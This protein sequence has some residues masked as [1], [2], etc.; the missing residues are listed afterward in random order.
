MHFHKNTSTNAYDVQPDGFLSA[1]VT[2]VTDVTL[3]VTAPNSR[4]GARC[5]NIT[6]ALSISVVSVLRVCFRSSR[7][8]EL[9]VTDSAASRM[10]R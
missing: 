1:C 3:D 9:L 2:P 7:I 10:V 4:S 5:F 6:S 8:L